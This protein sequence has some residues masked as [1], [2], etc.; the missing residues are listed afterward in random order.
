MLGTIILHIVNKELFS[1]FKLSKHFTPPPLM[2]KY[3]SQ[4]TFFPSILS[5]V[6]VLFHTKLKE[7]NEETGL[8]S[9]FTQHRLEWVVYNTQLPKFLPLRK[10]KKQ[11]SVKIFK[12]GKP[13]LPRGVF[14]G[15]IFFSEDI[16]RGNISCGAF[17]RGYFSGG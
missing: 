5:L 7:T 11:S 12:F 8:F 17:S 16:F 10:S 3:I 13:Y 4:I 14:T 6:F 9:R 15:G 2:C 1:D